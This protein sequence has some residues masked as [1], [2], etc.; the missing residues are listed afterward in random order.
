MQCVAPGGGRIIKNAVSWKKTF[1][2]AEDG[3]RDVERSRGLGD[4]YKRQIKWR[5]PD[6]IYFLPG[7]IRLSYFR[8]KLLKCIFFIHYVFV[9]SLYVIK[10]SW[11]KTDS[12]VWHNIRF[13]ML[14]LRITVAFEYLNGSLN[15]NNITKICKEFTSVE[16]C[17]QKA[18][19]W[20][21]KFVIWY[22]LK[23]LSNLFAIFIKRNNAL[24]CYSNLVFYLL[25]I[26]VYRLP[27]KGG[28]L[29]QNIL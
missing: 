18:L 25:L 9:V 17:M 6:K 26:F 7:T 11:T 14:R 5:P 13:L 12:A 21:C 4:V 23:I 10:Q 15:I 2:Q 29:L 3:I 8:Y 16:S 24:Y 20:K 1:F 19:I 22:L 27:H 28:G